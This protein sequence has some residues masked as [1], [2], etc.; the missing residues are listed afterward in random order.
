MKKLFKDLSANGTTGVVIEGGGEPTL[1]NKF[2][3]VV[4]YIK[5]LGLSIGLITNGVRMQYEQHLD[6]FDW[7]RISL[8]A[9]DKNQF[10]EGKKR[11]LF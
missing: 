5:D 9:T 4:S 7:I 2:N 8:D 3:D 1:Y 6:K 10:F 11:D